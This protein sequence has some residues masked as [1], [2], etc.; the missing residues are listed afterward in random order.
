VETFV[1]PSIDL[2][3]WFELTRDG[4]SAAPDAPAAV[5]VRRR[6]GLVI[7]PRGKSAMVY[8]FFA[9]S[10]ARQSLLTHFVDELDAP[11]SRGHGPLLFRFSTEDAAD[12]A[13]HHL[14]ETFV[15]RFGR[16]PILHDDG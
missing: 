3:A 14:Y 2:G 16:A 4:L 5:Q 8:Y 15:A 12:L 13:L 7:Y 1:Q 9:P 10:S 11:G 6:D